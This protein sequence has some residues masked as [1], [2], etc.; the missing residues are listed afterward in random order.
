MR[1]HL[2]ILT[3]IVCFGCKKNVKSP[4]VTT[5]G[6]TAL[7]NISARSG[8]TV[9]N[10]YGKPITARG[11][12]WSTSPNPTVVLSTKTVDSLGVGNFTSTI[13]GLNM[14]TTYYVKAYATNSAG[15]FYGNE[16]VFTTLNV[17]ITSGLVAYYPFNGNANDESGNSNNG[18][19]MGSVISTADRLGK[20]NKAYS[21]PGRSDS[22]IN[23][24]SSN[25]LMIRSAITMSAWI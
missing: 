23:C 2:I 5:N 18:S 12:V 16:I 11:V 14:N 6:V 10:D 13:T 25:S 17:D 15:T 9:S 22:Y 21:F 8:G 3:I 19:V 20:S 4:S 1:T 7:T 24:G